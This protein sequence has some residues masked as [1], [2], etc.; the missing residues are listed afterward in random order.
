MTPREPSDNIR[1]VGPYHSRV[2]LEMVES[3]HAALF[4]PPAEPDAPQVERDARTMAREMVVQFMRQW[5]R[6]TP[7]R[8]AIV[9]MRFCGLTWKEIGKRLGG[10]TPQAGEKQYRSA[11]RDLPELQAYF[12]PL[13][14]QKGHPNADR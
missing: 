8:S 14:N 3:H 10:I 6:L 1:G 11:I 12:A 2:P 7:R 4:I 13:W 9:Q 5:M